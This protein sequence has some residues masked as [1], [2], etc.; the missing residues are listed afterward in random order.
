[1]TSLGLPWMVELVVAIVGLVSA[2]IFLVLA[3]DAYQTEGAGPKESQPE[4]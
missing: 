1:M 2:G 4:A 3:A